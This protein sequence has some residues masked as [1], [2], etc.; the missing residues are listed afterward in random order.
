MKVV[1]IGGGI[2][3]LAAAW[4][5]CRAKVGAVTLLE[6][7][8]QLF[9]HSSGK[10]AAIYRCVESPRVVAELGV[11][12][13]GLLDQ[14]LGDRAAWLNQ[15]GLLLSARVRDPLVPLAQVSTE[16]GIEHEWLDQTELLRR[17]PAIA[18]GHATA[19]LWVPGGGVLD[20][21]AIS[22][23]LSREIRAGGGRIELGHDAARVRVDAGRVVGVESRGEV[24]SA[25]LVVIAGGAWASQVGATCGAPLPLVPVR[26][27]LVMLEPDQLPA[28]RSPT[29]WD[30][31]LGAYFRPESGALLASPGDAVPW[32]A[33]D[34]AADPAALELL[35]DRLGQ[36]APSL[37]SARVRRAWACLRTFAPD[38]ASVVGA[39]PRVSGLYWLAGLGG[40]GLTAGVAAGALLAKCIAGERDP[41]L[42]AVAPGRLV[43]ALVGHARG[44]AR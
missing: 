6:R 42:D 21:H 4:G 2:A 10:N 28:A 35:A 1:V 16:V 29:V 5:L 41:L 7:E 34:P 24:S 13:A 9:A 19:A 37:A 44:G 11:Q 12:S 20:N 17:A 3:G 15:D 39:D 18:G 31:E 38:K 26:R 8:P 14:L 32:H 22:T 33:E 27:H 40:H 36:M 30:A 23:A 25:D 43:G